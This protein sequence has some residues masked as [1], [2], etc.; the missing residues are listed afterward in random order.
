[1]DSCMNHTVWKE[2]FQVAQRGGQNV[3]VNSLSRKTA[4]NLGKILSKSFDLTKLDLRT[5]IYQTF[6]LV[7]FRPKVINSIKLK[8]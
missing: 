3:T 6:N 2:E 7:Q 8:K 1:M 4:S 5:H